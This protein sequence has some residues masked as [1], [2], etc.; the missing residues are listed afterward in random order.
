[1]R[2]GNY[3][4]T[5]EYDGLK[6]N[7]KICVKKA[8][9]QSEYVHTTLIP[10]Y[11]NVTTNYVYDCAYSLKTGFNGIIKMPKNELFTIQI[12][13]DTYSFSTSRIDGIDSTV[14]G[15]K[16]HLIPFDASGIKSDIDKSKLKGNGIIISQAKGYT[17]IAYRSITKDNT[18]LFGFYASK[19]PDSSEVL[20]YME[21]DVIT[22]KI[23]FRTQGY[24]ELGLK[25]SL[26]KFYGK[27]VY[28]FNYKS[29]DEITNHDTSSI[30]FAN[31]GKSVTFSYF[32]NY[33]VG[34]PSKEEIITKFIVNGREELEKTEA[35]SYGLS[36]KYRNSMGFEVVQ[37]YTIVT[38][39][40][41]KGILENWANRNPD[42]LDRF[43]VMNVYGMHLSSLETI[44]LADALA[45]KH[46]KEFGVTWK[47]DSTLTVLGGINLDDTYL[48]I[49]NAD[50]GMN[51]K[52]NEKNV[53]L[54]RLINSLCLPN[55]E[56]YSLS[57]VAGRFL[58]NTTNSL[59]NV[60]SAIS[61][62]RFSIAQLGDL[63]YIFS[64]DGEKSAIIL[65]ATS[66]VANVLVNNG[67]NTYKG[68]AI[69]TSGDCCS[70][71]IIPKDILGGIR[72]A[73]DIFSKGADSLS[74]VLDNLHPLSVMAYLGVKMVLEKT[75]Q[76]ASTTYLGL[77][78]I[79]AV[80]Q[81]AGTI[82]RDNVIDE[83]EWYRTMDTVTFTRP[84]YL[85][86]KKVYN[87]PNSNCG[88]DYV[89]VKINDDLTLDRNNATYIS[90]GKTKKLTKSETYKY[91]SED[92]WSPF[93]V[94][95]KYWDESW[96]GA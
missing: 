73:M 23:T 2:A 31:T 54:F 44:W 38:E 8:I 52:G 42:Y 19:G 78:S 33:I 81:T 10:D 40:I 3:T 70:V 86:G 16:S 62:N 65:N 64:Q 61:K 47:R 49:L 79:M 25:Y 28:D 85:Q 91:F 94:P 51:V 27:T 76:G 5:T 48:N 12:G 72:N 74:N 41:T 93:S 89:E 14:I 68:S 84:G 7:N 15:Y 26:S 39:K 88:Y 20:T 35:I 29:Y 37:S 75:L 71:G 21:G 77:F 30:R 53:V 55:L 22:A 9:I 60:L 57:G 59:D 32:R 1:M 66:G 6:N 11:V 87:I 43:G 46:A 18:A 67:D 17:E 82:Y 24:D 58:D 92:Y 45:D 50:M 80:T 56:D 96:K 13:Q 63:I 90:N 69:A 34:Y 4:I 95:A 36:E 83:K